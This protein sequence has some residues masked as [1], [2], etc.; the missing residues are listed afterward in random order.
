[1]RDREKNSFPLLSEN[2]RLSKIIEGTDYETVIEKLLK[3]EKS[4]K[5]KIRKLE[6]QASLCSF[7]SEAPS[8]ASSVPSSPLSFSTLTSSLPASVMGSSSPASI[9]SQPVSSGPTSLSTFFGDLKGVDLGEGGE[10]D[11][12]ELKE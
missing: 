3:N 6:L 10:E 11:K 2:Y 9:P 5:Q 4:L 12:Q 7:C 1:M 8:S